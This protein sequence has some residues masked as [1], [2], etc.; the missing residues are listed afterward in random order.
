MS[1]L[2]DV[3]DVFAGLDDLGAPATLTRTTPG[4]YNPTTGGNAAGTTTNSTTTAVLDAATSVKLG[5]IFGP[6]LVQGGDIM[7]MIPA[8]GL[9][10]A[11]LPGD[12]L[13]VAGWTYKV[14]QVVPTWA[15]SVPVVY[16]ML[17]RK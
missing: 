8:K 17:V 13:T 6:A 4:A 10:S 2:D 3:A 16:S 5:F 7:A 1:L 14:V 15:G 11:P 9:A 12:T